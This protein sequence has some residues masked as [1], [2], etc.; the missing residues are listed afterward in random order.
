MTLSSSTRPLTSTEHDTL[1]RTITTTDH[2]ARQS[3]ATP[4][5][6]TKA[7]RSKDSHRCI[8]IRGC[9]PASGR[10]GTARVAAAHSVD[11]PKII[12][13]WSGC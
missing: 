7:T 4:E 12:P 1:S 2:Y 6:R 3:N 9:G 10:P 8:T 5:R 13:G 11:L